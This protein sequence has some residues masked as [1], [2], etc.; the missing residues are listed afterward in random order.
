MKDNKAKIINFKQLGDERGKLVV[1]EGNQ[2]I[3]FDIARVFYIY[4][5]DGTV[6]RGQHANRRSEFLLINVCGSS[7]VKVD[8]GDS[9]EIFELDNPFTALFIPK[10]VWKDMYDFSENSVL[11]V[12]SNE[13]YDSQEYIRDYSEYLKE[14]LVKEM[15]KN[16]N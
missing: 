2:D 6:I 5:S 8:Y 9:Y 11:L 1:I 12:M 4:E 3:P 7:K 13:K 15:P 10:M 14:V 16:E